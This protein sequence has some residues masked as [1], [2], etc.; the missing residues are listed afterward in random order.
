MQITRYEEV[1]SINTNLDPLT[2]LVTWLEYYCATD[3][4]VSLLTTRHGVASAAAKTR[5]Q[6]VRPHARLATQ[7]IQEANSR[8][9]RVAFS[10]NFLAILNLL[11]IYILFGPHY[12]Q[13]PANRWHG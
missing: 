7:Y 13:L 5:A 9:C 1:E 4:V 6:L 11:K 8:P 12:A 3:Y 2:D 10:S